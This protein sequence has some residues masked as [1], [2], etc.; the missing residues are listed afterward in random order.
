[1]VGC[2]R[3]VVTGATGFLGGAVARRLASVPGVEVV[4]TGRN[5]R[6]GKTLAEAG[7]DFR[8][9]DLVDADAV[10]TLLRG[11]D[12]VLHCAALSSPWGPRKDFV[13]ANVLASRNVVNACVDANLQRLV[14]ISTPGVYHD[15]HP[16]H[17][18]REDSALPRPA[19]AY[20][21]TKR[22]A[23]REVLS[24]SASSGLSTVVLR[25]RALFGPGD[26]AILPRIAN[27]L[28]SGRLLRIGNGSCIVDMTYIDNA[29]DAT[30]LALN[31]GAACSGRIYNISNGEPVRIWD[32]I[33]QLAD[34]MHLRRPVK[35]VP[36]AL[37]AGLATAVELSY[38]LAG[39]RSEP[40]ILR[41][42]VELLGVDMTLDISR[43]R[44][45]LSYPPRVP[46]ETAL[47]ITFAA[48]ARDHAVRER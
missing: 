43:A 21:E 34:A 19:N 32:V 33:D 7:L 42:G 9:V 36:L 45:E 8:N 5:A 2:R 1:M 41:Y 24:A 13:A 12:A 17:G 30:L 26:T 11:A 20:I 38:R 47:Q 44:D 25:P 37:A 31:A 23:E 28:Q 40:P 46:M 3:V 18:L 16:H 15:G 10:A 27:A 14:H 39:V 6:R 35:R 4:A 29:V 48:L 22:I